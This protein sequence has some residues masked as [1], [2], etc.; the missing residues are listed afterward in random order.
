MAYFI[1]A[2]V[3]FSV[4]LSVIFI[5]ISHLSR[6]EQK[7]LFIFLIIVSIVGIVGCLTQV[8]MV[9]KAIGE[10]NRI[11]KVLKESWER[12]RSVIAASNTGAW[13]YHSDTSYLW[14]SPEY[15]RMLGCE[16][17]D[18]L[19]DGKLNIDDVWVNRLHPDDKYKVTKKFTEYLAAGSPGMYENHFRMHHKNGNY[20]WIWSRAQTL[21]NADGNISKV[22]LGTHI[23]VTD[24]MNLEI[25]LLKHNEKLMKYAHLNAHEV[26]G[27]LARL[28][29]LIE[30]SKLDSNLN[31]LWFFEKI[32]DEAT[33]IDKILKT[34]TKELNEIEERK[35][36]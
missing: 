22:T 25:E 29:G 9:I 21:R 15:F 16:E 3:M 12:Y 7:P 30:V 6:S 14:T 31:F 27:P 28:L 26:R 19:K 20:I 8:I 1:C 34:I 13:E 11:E 24:K 5:S 33:D 10:E 2:A 18:F 36:T 4:F 35:H 32:K 17:K 23:D